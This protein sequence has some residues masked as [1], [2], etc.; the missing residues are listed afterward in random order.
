MVGGRLAVVAV[1]LLAGCHDVDKLRC[2]TCQNG[3]AGGT[4]GT[5]GSSGSDGTAMDAL[6]DLAVPLPDAFLPDVPRDIAVEKAMP[7]KSDGGSTCGITC[8][9][10]SSNGCNSE[11]A[12]LPDC[13]MHTRCCYHYGVRRFADPCIY[14]NDCAPGLICVGDPYGRGFY[15]HKT[16]NVDSDCPYP[17]TE[18]RCLA[19]ACQDGSSTSSV[20]CSFPL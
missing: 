9:Y 8:D 20:V 10:L 14:L 7:P 16:C 12:C 3:D 1:L 19:I 17:A 18:G 2:P 5:G 4:G 6:V 11:Y 15:C 13:T